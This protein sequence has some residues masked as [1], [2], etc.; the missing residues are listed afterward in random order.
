MTIKNRISRNISILATI[1]YGVIASVV[2][3]LFSNFRNSEFRRR[4]EEKALTSVQLL[5]DV[6]EKDQGLLRNFEQNSIEKSYDAR[7]YVFDSTRHLIYSSHETT[8]PLWD[9]RDLDALQQSGSYFHHKNEYDMYGE[10]QEHKGKKYYVIVAAIDRVGQRDITYLVYLLLAAYILF[11]VL[12]WFMTFYQVKKQLKPIDYFHKKISN[13][14]EHNL[15]ERLS[16]PEKAKKNEIDLIGEEFNF[17]MN[18]IE[19]AYRQQKEFTAHASHELRTPLARLS[20]QIENLISRSTGEQR[21]T[22][23]RALDDTHQLNELIQSLLILARLDNTK[24]DFKEK[25]RIDEAIY[26]SIGYVKKQFPDFKV[27]LSMDEMDQNESSLEIHANQSL[28]EIA[29]NNILRNA[30]L[31]SSNKQAEIEIKNEDNHILI[32]FKNDGAGLSLDEQE[33]LF[34]PFMR[35]KQSKSIPGLGLGLRIVH[36]ILNVYK[37]PIRYDYIHGLNIF[38]LTFFQ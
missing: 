17:M 1:L 6:D 13:I 27:S 25:S 38:T 2:F 33:R 29:F 14:N 26:N 32:T 16:V 20:T 7:T 23:S 36:R 21:E 30:Y 34:T 10:Y 22:L 18:R 28:I 11:T 9:V 3:I 12:T 31:Y 15:E 37:Y 4:L 35:G 24:R 19:N 5:L 8:S